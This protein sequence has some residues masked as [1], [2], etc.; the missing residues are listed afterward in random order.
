[1]V[2]VAV[3]RSVSEQVRDII[4]DA[5]KSIRKKSKEPDKISIN[6]HITRNRT[7]FKEVEL[8]DSIS[9]LVDSEILIN[10]KSKQDLDSLFVNEGTSTDNTPQGQSN[11]LPDI[12]P[13]DTETIN[14]SLAEASRNSDRDRFNGLKGKVNNNPGNF[15]AF[16]SFVLDELHKIKEKVCNLRI[17]NPDGSNLVKN[18]KGEINFL[19][20]RISCKSLIIKIL[21]ENINNQENSKSYNSLYNDFTYGNKNFK[22]KS[23]NNNLGD[24][25]EKDFNIRK[26]NFENKNARRNK[27]NFMN[28]NIL[29]SNGFDNLLSVENT[30]NDAKID[31][32]I[33]IDVAKARQI[34]FVRSSKST[35][36]KRP[37]VIIN[38]YSE[39]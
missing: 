16:K 22:S 7:N 35:I 32:V 14:C 34:L 4:F 3:D 10:K 20:E 9:K 36:K 27:A 15:S 1:M 11:T 23:F 33:E 5:I 18:L 26:K 37:E 30:Q 39:N 2:F 31:D 17:Q 24:T 12:T 6:E 13:V 25:P 8:R 21:A 29:T 38:K 19:R 28:F